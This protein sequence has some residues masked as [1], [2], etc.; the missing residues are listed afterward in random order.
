VF[1]LIKSNSWLKHLI[2]F[3]RCF[4]KNDHY[5][6]NIFLTQKSKVLYNKLFKTIQSVQ[7]QYLLTKQ[8]P[9]NIC[10]HTDRANRRH[11]DTWRTLN[12]VKIINECFLCPFPL[13]LVSF[14][15]AFTSNNLRLGC[16]VK[17]FDQIWDVIIIDICCSLHAI[18]CT[19]RSC[20]NI[21]RSSEFA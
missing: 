19:Q 5:A 2:H 16:F 20:P 17:V 14:F 6:S 13:T 4:N 3:N 15:T 8:V 1:I 10:R 18:T 9:T 21:T 11:Q 7:K 12:M